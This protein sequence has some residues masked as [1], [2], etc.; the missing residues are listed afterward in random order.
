MEKKEI[1]TQG[2]ICQL[3]PVKTRRL[4]LLE[5]TIQRCSHEKAPRKNAGSP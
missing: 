3:M 5:A 1:M 2:N 4:R